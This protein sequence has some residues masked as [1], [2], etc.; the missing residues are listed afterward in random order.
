[1]CE[2]NTTEKKPVEPGDQERFE[3]TAKT[4]GESPLLSEKVELLPTEDERFE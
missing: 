3:I 4:G 2:E 1:M